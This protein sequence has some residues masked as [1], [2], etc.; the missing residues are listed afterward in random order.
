MVWTKLDEEPQKSEQPKAPRK[1]RKSVEVRVLSQADIHRGIAKIRR[2]IADIQQLE[3]D[4]VRWDSRRKEDLE[5]KVT[6]LIRDTFGPNSREL[7]DFEGF[8]IGRDGDLDSDDECQ[9]SFLA[10]IPDAVALLNGVIERLEERIEYTVDGFAAKSA[11]SAPAPLS[12]RVFIVHGH[13]DVAKDT[14]ARLLTQLKLEPIILH[15][16]PNEGRTIIE[17]FEKSADVYFA[18]VLLTP[19]DLGSTRRDLVTAARPRARQNVIFEL[20]FFIGKL[21]RGRV[22]ALH[23]GETEIL[24]D[25]HGVVFV[26]MDGA[27]AWKLL[28]AREMKAA[29]LSIDMN[30][31]L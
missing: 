30:L 6:E 21:G 25:Y 23:K 24:S 7:R 1:P 31:V 27:G 17:K 2:R 28:L 26:Q 13:D 20:G 16:Q 14:T 3:T 12:R 5:A 19:D 8:S 9:E 15:E 10:G 22:C 11:G 18:V 29:G 4:R